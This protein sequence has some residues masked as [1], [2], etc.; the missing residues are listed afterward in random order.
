[1]WLQILTFVAL[2]SEVRVNKEFAT[3]G[4]ECTNVSELLPDNQDSNYQVYT[5][6]LSSMGTDFIVTLSWVCIFT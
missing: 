1:M 3:T 2:L 5:P 4:S 6:S